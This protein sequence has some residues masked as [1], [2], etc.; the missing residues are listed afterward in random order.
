MRR[1]SGR[2]GAAGGGG[3]PGRGG[4]GGRRAAGVVPGGPA[5]LALDPGHQFQRVEGFGDVIVRPQ[6]EPGDLVHILAP[7]GEHQDGEQMPLPDALAQ[8]EAVHV[9]QHHIQDRQ[10]GRVGL[11]GGQRRL[12]R[13]KGL[14]REALGL[15]VDGHQLRDLLFIIHYQHLGHR[16]SPPLSGARRA[17]AGL[18]KKYKIRRRRAVPA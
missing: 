14:H 6:R 17:C 3:W 7:G 1:C 16:C 5:Q 8:R 11:H 12:R 13:G 15:Q 10:V 4:A 18:S 9:G 2:A